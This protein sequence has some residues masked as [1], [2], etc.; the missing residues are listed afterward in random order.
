MERLFTAWK[1]KNLEIQNR[2][3]VPPMVCFGWSDESGMVVDKNVE[4]YRAMAK[5]GPGLIIQEATC[6]SENGRLSRAQLGIWSDAHV[7]GLKRIVEAVHGEGVSLLLQIHHA[8]VVS[9]T[10]DPVCPSDYSLV[11]KG[12]ERHGRELSVEEIQKIEGDFIE[13]ARRAYEAGYDG[14]ELHGCHNYLLCQFFNRRVNRRTD[15]Y[16]AEDMQIVKNII[17]G[18]RKVTPPEF[19]VGIRLGAFEPE[20]SDGVA[21]A[22]KLEAM[23][24]DF[25]NV[26]YG[27]DKEA[28]RE[29]PQGYPFAEAIYGAERIRAAVQVP[30][31]AVYG[32]QDG[33]T[34]EA[35]LKQTGADMVNI[36]RGVL[37]NYNWASDVKAGR[38]PGKCL[39]CK[40]CMWRSDPD[41]CAG[42]LLFN[43]KR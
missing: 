33:E 17:D 42:K 25:I 41:R 35:V 9:E 36:G 13:A 5:G 31:F 22:K 1:L 14:V 8:G 7:L 18:I 12:R 39:Y 26:S 30:V 29:K 19:V 24:I 15:L 40:T 3:C 37:V 10:E 20:I 43:R 4:H 11:F 28:V 21:H 23:G 32:I 16:N 27:F 34:A 6:V 38:N 2:I